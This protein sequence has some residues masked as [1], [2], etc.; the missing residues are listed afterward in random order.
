M[1]D[2]APAPAASPVLDITKCK[3]ASTWAN[4]RPLV[5]CRFD[6]KMRFVFCGAEEKTVVRFRLS[7]GAK[8]PMPG[9]HETWVHGLVCTPDGEWVISGGCEGRM[10]WWPIA[11]ETPTPA[12]QVAA[13]K[14]GSGNWRS[15][16]MARRSLRPEMTGWSGCGR[17]PTEPW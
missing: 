11:A 3:V 7:D 9:G 8:T 10:T 14:A 16:R 2:S 17:R 5:A 12:R 13:H 1:P 4:D 15:A 6:P